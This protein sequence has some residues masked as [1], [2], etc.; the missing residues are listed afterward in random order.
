MA[1]AI[2]IITRPDLVPTVHG[3][4]VKIIRTA[5]ALSRLGAR[6]TVVTND[7]L[8]FY[9]AQD[10]L[11]NR[12]RYP[13]ALLSAT[14]LPPFLKAP[15][16]ERL[17]SLK[18][19]TYWQG[20]AS[21]LNRLGYPGDE[22]FLY[23]PMIDPDFWLRVLYIGWAHQIDVYQAEF[24]GYA[25]PAILAART[26]GG[27]SALVQHNV[28]YKR[29]SDTTDIPAP[30]LKRLRRLEAFCMRSVDHLIAVSEVDR[31]L[32][33]QDGVPDAKIAVIPHGVDLDAYQN[34]SSA[35]IRRRYQIPEAVPLLVFH[36]TLHYWPNTVAVKHI[37]CDLL[38]R[39]EARGIHVKVMICGMNPPRYYAHPDIIFT[40]V[41]QDLPSHLMAADLAIV[42]LDDGGGTRLKILEY[43]AAGLPVISTSKGAEG[44]TAPPGEALVI[45]DGQDAFAEAVISL[46]QAPERARKIGETG[47][48]FVQD[49]AWDALCAQYMT[50]YGFAVAEPPA[51]KPPPV[52]PLAPSPSTPDS[53]ETVGWLAGGSPLEDPAI[54]GHIPVPLHPTKPLTMIMMI[55]RGCNLR[56]D[57]CDL[58]ERPERFA[59]EPAQKI[60]MEAAGMGVKTVVFT[61]GEPFMH[62]DLWALIRLASDLGMG[63]NVTTNGTLIERHLDNILASGLSSVSVSLDGLEETHEALRKIK[64]CHA[65][66][67]H[68]IELLREKGVPTNVYFVVTGQNVEELIPVYDLAHRMGCGFDFW[69]VND[70]H[71]LYL[72]TPEHR[73]Q[74]RAVIQALADRD[75]QV[76]AKHDYY[77][78]GL[79]YHA[80]W[81]KR[82]RCLG[83]IEQFGVNL[84]GDL[85]PCCVWDNTDLTVGSLK[86]SSL[87]E[88]FYGAEAQ[89]RR[90]Q[91]FEQGCH[92]R[93]F[94]HSLYEFQLSTGL[95]FVVGEG[96]LETAPTERGADDST[97]HR[98]EAPA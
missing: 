73:A 4:A 7:R 20:L 19:P 42:P 57:F 63:T 49:Y 37:A 18:I 8:W 86:E 77:L 32:M 1:K 93:C 31:Q 90:T 30:V 70:A 50:R 84:Q 81:D 66:T 79:D 11:V 91:I 97:E 67:L 17:A 75:A 21:L 51:P 71:H 26:L 69:P 36:G 87:P 15:L 78:A 6:V 9:E 53:A 95:S 92:N 43:F 41:V 10:G 16:E 82:V 96:A 39:L 55:N 25:I 38:P 22:H 76:A 60:I 58:Y 23:Q 29:L 88:L 74:Y 35:G 83:L 52:E 89:A 46:L 54:V 68:G 62:P 56:C 59:L 33:L 13:Q 65:K 24:P 27:Q 2:C 85:V 45:A 14:N 47:R 44:I 94:N 3:A 61:G 72:L 34:V 5:E 12:K 80:G 48:R 40:D 28:E 98:E 64:G